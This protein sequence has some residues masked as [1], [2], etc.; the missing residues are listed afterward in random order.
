MA[1]DASSADSRLAGSAKWLFY[2]S[3]ILYKARKSWNN[4]SGKPV[5][6]WQSMENKNLTRTSWPAFGAN[7][8][9]ILFTSIAPPFLSLGFIDDTIAW[10]PFEIGTWQG[11]PIEHAKRHLVNVSHPC[12]SPYH[13]ISPV[14]SYQL[15]N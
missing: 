6:C 5:R 10:I 1:H 13:Y 15:H 3:L 7:Y 9:V 12:I 2:G 8:R 14:E 11:C 4:H